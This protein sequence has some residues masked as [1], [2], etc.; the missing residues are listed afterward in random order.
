MAEAEW[1]KEKKCH[2]STGNCRNMKEQST[3]WLLFSTGTSFLP[4]RI[5]RF[6]Y[7]LETWQWMWMHLDMGESKQPVLNLKHFQLLLLLSHRTTYL[8]PDGIKSCQLEAGKS[9][10]PAVLTSYQDPATRISWKDLPLLCLGEHSWVF[11]QGELAPLRWKNI[12]NICSAE[13]RWYWQ[14]EVE[15]CWGC[16]KSKRWHTTFSKLPACAYLV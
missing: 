4:E 7:I 8:E 5:C 15:G 1:G 2:D 6:S 11:L 16:Q 14:L 3:Q 10:L 12:W 13:L 9:R